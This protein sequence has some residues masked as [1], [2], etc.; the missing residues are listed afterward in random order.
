MGGIEASWGGNPYAA[1]Q[2]VKVV[3]VFE[4]GK[5]YAT[6]CYQVETSPRPEPPLVAAMDRNCGQI[7]VAYSDGTRESYPQP[8]VGIVH[9][10]LKRAQRKLSQQKKGSRR[11]G[12]H[13]V[14]DSE[15]TSP[16]LQHRQQL[17]P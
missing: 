7:A 8:K 10:R 2:P 1:D 17:A 16:G 15:A 3:V 14:T 9:V 5:W 6:V 11:R 12:A 4:A 13:Q